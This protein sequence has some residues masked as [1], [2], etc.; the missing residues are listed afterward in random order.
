[1]SDQNVYA[2]NTV[3]GVVTKVDSAFLDHPT[4]GAGLVEVEDPNVCIDCGEQPGAVTT[5]KG[6]LI[7]LNKTKRT[8]GGS[9]REP[10]KAAKPIGGEQP[11]A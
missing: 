7:D 5:T 2:L 9:I 11:N 10:A 3:S 1:M 6:E 4:L 8:Q